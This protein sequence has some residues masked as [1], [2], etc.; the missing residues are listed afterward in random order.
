MAHRK[1]N[2]AKPLVRAIL[3]IL[4]KDPR[5]G[6]YVS[7]FTKHTFHPTYYSEFLPNECFPDR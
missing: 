4:W 1:T 2:D 5:Y 6:G 7:R 3:W